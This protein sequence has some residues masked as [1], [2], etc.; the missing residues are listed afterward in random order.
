MY[1]HSPA[2]STA[3]EGP[4]YHRGWPRASFSFSFQQRRLNF[5]SGLSSPLGLLQVVLPLLI[6]ISL[7]A[8]QNSEAYLDI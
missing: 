2:A 4:V 5:G 1:R 3:K 6:H 7:T 8:D